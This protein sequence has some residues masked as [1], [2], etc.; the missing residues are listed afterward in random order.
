MVSWDAARGQMGTEQKKFILGSE[1][2][3]ECDKF[4]EHILA[5]VSGIKRNSVS[6]AS[7]VHDESLDDD[8]LRNRRGSVGSTGTAGSLGSFGGRSGYSVASSAAASASRA[9]QDLKDQDLGDLTDVERRLL[10]AQCTSTLTSISKANSRPD[11]L[12]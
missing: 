4:I 8:W 6:R 11:P 12:I 10:S 9:L 2:K 3:V 7:L 1:Y 5:N